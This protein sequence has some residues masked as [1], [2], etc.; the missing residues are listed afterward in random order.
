[1]EHQRFKRAR[2]SSIPVKE[3]M[4][5]GEVVVR[6]ERLKDWIVLTVFVLKRVRKGIK[7]SLALIPAIDAAVPWRAEV[8]VIVPTPKLSR[9]AMV[10]IRPCDDPAMDFQNQ[11]SIDR[12]IGG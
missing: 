3:R 9:G 10:I 11:I 1:L 8:H 4:H 7:R 12:P 6:G 5:G 2:R